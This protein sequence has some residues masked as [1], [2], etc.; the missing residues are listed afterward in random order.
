MERL[1]SPGVG[2][3]ETPT[4]PHGLGGTGTPGEM[5]RC[6]DPALQVDSQR[7]TCDQCWALGQQRRSAHGRAPWGQEGSGLSPPTSPASRQ[8]AG[9]FWEKHRGQRGPSAAAGQR[10]VSEG[11]SSGVLQTQPTLLSP[12]GCFKHAADVHRW[13]CWDGASS[14]GFASCLFFFQMENTS[15]GPTFGPERMSP[16]RTVMPKAGNTPL[17][18]A[19]ALVT[20]PALRHASCLA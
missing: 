5:G 12:L 7:L 14:M 9:S 2:W 6:R 20:F 16:L 15:H 10:K 11:I 13:S 18:A 4:P 19:F 17:A 8:V 3:Q 1:P